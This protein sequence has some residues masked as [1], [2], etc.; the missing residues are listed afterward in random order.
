MKRFCLKLGI[1]L[2]VKVILGFFH[3]VVAEILMME[4]TDGV[5]VQSWRKAMK[6][7]KQVRLLLNQILLFK[8]SRIKISAFVL[9]IFRMNWE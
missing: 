7:M 4:E 9:S 5:L 6:K 3:W 8:I 1:L 2:K